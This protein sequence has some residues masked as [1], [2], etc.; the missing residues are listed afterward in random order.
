MQDILTFEAEP[1]V[2][3]FEEEIDLSRESGQYEQELTAEQEKRLKALAR[4]IAESRGHRVRAGRSRRNI[5]EEG[6]AARAKAIYK[7]ALRIAEQQGFAAALAALERDREL[8]FLEL[9]EVELAS[10]T[11]TPLGGRSGRW[12][13]RGNTIVVLDT[14]GH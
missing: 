12:Y 9:Y 3:S 7:R 11:R 13:R 8:E 5:H 4:Q 10:D 1:F 14:F 2:V 6:I